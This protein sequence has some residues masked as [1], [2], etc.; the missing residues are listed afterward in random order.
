MGWHYPLLPGVR[1]HRECVFWVSS[2]LTCY[3]FRSCH[4]HAKVGCEIANQQQPCVA[5]AMF[6]CYA[7]FS[8]RLGISAGVDHGSFVKCLGSLAHIVNIVIDIVS[9]RNRRVPCGHANLI[10]SPKTPNQQQMGSTGAR[11]RK[12]QRQPGP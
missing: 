5:E 4:G 3:G 6:Q 10:L 11:P 8:I 12:F 2:V 9:S 7:N 1:L